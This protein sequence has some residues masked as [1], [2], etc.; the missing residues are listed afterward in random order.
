VRL[1]DLRPEWIDHEGRR[2]IG[3]RF[4]C[5]TGHCNGKCWV[6]FVNPLDGGEAWK[7]SGIKL[8]HNYL[9]KSGFAGRMDRPCHLTRWKRT[10]D[11]FESM[12]MSPSVNAWKCGHYTLLNGVWT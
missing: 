8:M 10:G 5:M 11:R 7:G 3:I 6:L 9:E 12:S 1:A 4:D 2:G